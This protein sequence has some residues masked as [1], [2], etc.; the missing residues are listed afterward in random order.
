M[1][2]A[3]LQEGS[4]VGRARDRGGAGK[5][6]S[7]EWGTFQCPGRATGLGRGLPCGLCWLSGV[8]GPCSGPGPGSPREGERRVSGVCGAGEAGGRGSLPED[9]GWDL[10]GVRRAW[11]R[12]P[13]ELVA[14]TECCRHHERVSDLGEAAPGW[15]W[16]SRPCLHLGHFFS[17][18]CMPR[19]ES[20][21]SYG[22]RQVVSR[23][24]V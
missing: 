7:R 12:G 4:R 17:G 21:A 19:P 13:G 2:Q 23:L 14:S 6:E 16:S 24:C 10:V 3:C 9:V 20:G 18:R 5:S 8:G 1:N 22:K 11:L 15:P